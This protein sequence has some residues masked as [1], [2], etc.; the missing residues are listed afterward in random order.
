MIASYHLLQR[1]KSLQ[2]D[3]QQAYSPIQ[4]RP[5]RRYCTR[6]DRPESYTEVMNATYALER[7]MEESRKIDLTASPMHVL[8]TVR[9]LGVPCW[10]MKLMGDSACVYYLRE[11]YS[12]ISMA[13]VKIVPPVSLTHANL[14]TSSKYG[15]DMPHSTHREKS[16]LRPDLSRDI[17]PEEL[18][19]GRSL[20]EVPL[21]PRSHSL[22]RQID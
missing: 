5:S 4:S 19:R 12:M 17:S 21:I 9:P 2:D 20:E 3:H 7:R 8:L 1:V 22:E 14:Q 15:T 10:S 18:C 11:C 16:M 13:I 6:R